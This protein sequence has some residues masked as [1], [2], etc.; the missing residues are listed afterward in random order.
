MQPSSKDKKSDVDL[1]ISNPKSI[2]L[3]I[4]LAEDNAL[5]EAHQAAV[6]N[7]LSFLE[8]HQEMMNADSR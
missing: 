8:Q 7:S 1:T 5:Q 3:F 2:S 6:N 4:L